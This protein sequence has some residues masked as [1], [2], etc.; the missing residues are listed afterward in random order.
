M[1]LNTA[2]LRPRWVPGM[3]RMLGL[4]RGPLQALVWV[5]WC[6]TIGSGQTVSTSGQFAAAVAERPPLQ[7]DPLTEQG[8]SPVITAL[9]LSPDGRWLAAAG[10]DH[11][12]RIIDF[13]NWRLSETL[14][15]HD[16]WIHAVRFTTDGQWLV[17]GGRDGQLRLWNARQGWALAVESDFGSAISDIAVSPHSPSVAVVG[18]QASVGLWSVRDRDWTGR[19]ATSHGDLRGVGFSADG[20]RLAVGGRG[21]WISVWQMPAGGLPKTYQAHRRRIHQVA[22]GGTGD[23]LFS[24]GEDGLLVTSL[25]DRGEVIDRQ[26]LGRTKFMALERLPQGGWVLAGSDNLL[27]L[28]PGSQET[29]PRWLE[30]HAGSVAALT[31]GHGWLVSGGYDT[32]IRCWPL[33]D[34]GAAQTGAA[35]TWF[36]APSSPAGRPISIAPSKD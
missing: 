22:F 3:G 6:V 28:V 7:L 34:V 8:L 20:Q 19:L 5:A 17:S 13:T 18:F 31:A 24:A 16:D 14:F 36:S 25:V 30:G 15:G 10:D 9:D 11:A 27:T 33:S 12:I 35:G 32:T 1:R 29:A 4:G 2:V 23:Q 21:G 26:D